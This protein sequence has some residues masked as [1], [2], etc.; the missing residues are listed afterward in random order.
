[1]VKFLLAGSWLAISALASDSRCTNK[2]GT[3]Q[4][5][6]QK[7]NGHYESG[8]CDGAA[9]RQCCIEDNDP[10]YKCNFI[11]GHCQNSNLYTCKNGDYLSGY[12]SGASNIKCCVENNCPLYKWSSSKIKGYYHD[13]YVEDGFKSYMSII[14]DEAS[15][16]GIMFYVTQAYRKDGVDPIDPIVKPSSTS[17]HLVGH[18]VD[19]N[20]DTKYGWCNG[21]CM[22]KAWFSRIYNP[23]AYD[24][25]HGVVNRGVRFGVS[26]NDPVHFDD[27]LNINHKSTWDRLFAD[28]QP[29]CNNLDV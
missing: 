10:D 5:N 20:L 12:C 1:M 3:C 7:C 4:T 11:G 13:V 24:F 28:I 25:L 23:Q 8:I 14:Q 18:A 21:D 16:N 19:A 9:N 15:K 22:E 27:T 26:F 2:F 29:K 17:N 6:T